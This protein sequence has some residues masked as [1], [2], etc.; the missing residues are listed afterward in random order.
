MGLFDF[1]SS[2]KR[3]EAAAVEE[4]TAELHAALSAHARGAVD[5]SAPPVVGSGYAASVIHDRRNIDPLVRAIQSLLPG[6]AGHHDVELRVAES[7]ATNAP[8]SL[9]LLPKRW[10]ADDITVMLR[11]H[12]SLLALL[13]QYSLVVD[14]WYLG[15]TIKGVARQD[16]AQVARLAIEWWA[17]LMD[18]EL[19]GWPN[20]DLSVEVGDLHEPEISYVIGAAPDADDEAFENELDSANETLPENETVSEAETRINAARA[21]SA[22]IDKLRILDAVANS[23]SR[24]GFR[25]ELGFTPTTLTP[26]V[27]V[28]DIDSGEKDE[29]ETRELTADLNLLSPGR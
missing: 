6:L 8:F 13:P 26:R 12:A 29:N 5:T 7:E 18:S 27:K 19:A 24:P 21:V 2:A 17:G 28:I 10:N 16:A 3:A 20:S 15:F 1:L 23:R 4:G 22:G 25:I 14:G 11:V 9:I